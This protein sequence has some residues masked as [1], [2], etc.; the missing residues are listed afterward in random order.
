MKRILMQPCYLL[1]LIAM[2]VY[3]ASCKSKED[4]EPEPKTDEQILMEKLSKTWLLESASLEGEP[5]TDF[6]N[7]VLTISEGTYS[8]K[9]EFPAQSP[10]PE[11]GTWK[12]DSND[13]NNLIIRDP[14]TSDEVEMSYVVSE[15]G[16]ELS[17]TFNVSGEGWEGGSFGNRVLG[18]MGKW[19]FTFTASN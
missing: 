10:W 7:V 3:V 12:F 16:K 8:L 18:L 11:S 13:I 19:K 9:G 1:I 2:V 14:G 4:P 15:N 5:R 17:F 6:E